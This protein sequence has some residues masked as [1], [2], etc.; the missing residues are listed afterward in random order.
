MIKIREPFNAI[1]HLVGAIIAV[2]GTAYLLSTRQT[3]TAAAVG[4]LI[5]GFGAV[6]MFGSSSLYHWTANAKSWLQKLDHSAIYMMIA[7]SYTPICLLALP[8]GLKYK[9]LG[10]QWG[11]ASVGIIS[12]ILMTKPPTWLRLTLYLLMGW[13]VLPLVNSISPATAGTAS[14]VIGWMVAG[15]LFYT[16]GSVI[17]ASKKP[18]LWPGKFGFHELWHLFVLGGF[19]CHFAMMTRI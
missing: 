15:G 19:G 14:T 4:F 18:T 13:M 5:F 2:L 1:S 8:D 11:L 16:V 10:L 3:T 9:I 7:G 6:M 17:Y 12:T